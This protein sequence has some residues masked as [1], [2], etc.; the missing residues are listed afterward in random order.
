MIDLIQRLFI[1]RH[2]VSSGRTSGPPFDPPLVSDFGSFSAKCRCLLSNES[3]VTS[4]IVRLN[5]PL[6]LSLS[7]RQSS[8]PPSDVTLALSCRTR[9][10]FH[11]RAHSILH[12][13]PRTSFHTHSHPSQRYACVPFDVTVFQR[14]SRTKLIYV[15]SRVPL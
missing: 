12:H 4:F 10:A 6:S 7:P 2:L 3:L 11:F 9:P 8:R 15:C 1:V 5:Q 13:L 14:M